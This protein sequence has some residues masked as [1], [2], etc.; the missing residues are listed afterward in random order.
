MKAKTITETVKVEQ[1]TA[2]LAAHG[3]R[4]VRGGWRWV[5][6]HPYLI[7]GPEL[8]AEAKTEEVKGDETD[9]EE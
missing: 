8:P 4:V 1:L 2:Y 3:L 7:T 9:G 6:R 5:D